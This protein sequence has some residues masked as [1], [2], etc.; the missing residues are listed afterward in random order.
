MKIKIEPFYLLCSTGTCGHEGTDLDGVG[1]ERWVA[2]VRYQCL[3]RVQELISRM[4][5]HAV[6]GFLIP[7]LV[8]ILEVKSQESRVKSQGTNKSSFETHVPSKHVCVSVVHILVCCFAFAADMKS[9]RT[10]Q[11]Y[12]RPIKA[13]QPRRC[14]LRIC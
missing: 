12:Y 2:R 6:F 13:L 10:L 9:Q 5:Y 8:G 14:H 1:S 11:K 3:N 7:M 4:P